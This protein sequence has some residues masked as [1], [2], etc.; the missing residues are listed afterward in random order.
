MNK[1][2]IHTL[3][4]PEFSKTMAR[5]KE[6]RENDPTLQVVGLIDKADL[7]NE[8]FMRNI[9]EATQRFANF[10]LEP[11]DIIIA[12]NEGETRFS[13]AEWESVKALRDRLMSKGITFGFDDYRQIWSVEEVETANAKIDKSADA[14]RGKSFSPL[15]KLLS[16][17]LDVTR[18]NYK[19]EDQTEHFSQSRSVMGVLNSD[20]IVCVGFSA[21]LKAIIEREGDQNI[22]IFTNHVA[23]SRDNEYVSGYH[24]NLVIYINDPKYGL[25][26][27][28]YVDPTWDCSRGQRQDFNLNHFLVPLKDIEHLNTYILDTS[29]TKPKAPAT[30]I[31]KAPHVTVKTAKAMAKNKH[32][33]YNAYLQR[34]TSFSGE[35]FVMS[36]ELKEHA[37]GN[38]SLAQ[39]L[40]EY[41]ALADEIVNDFE[42]HFAVMGRALNDIREYFVELGMTELPNEVGY[43]FDK[44]IKQGKGV[45]EL[46]AYADK[47]A[48]AYTQGVLNGNKEEMKQAFLSN[49][50]TKLSDF[51]MVDFYAS[52]LASLER[53]KGMLDDAEH[54]SAIEDCKQKLA[55]QTEA[56]EQILMHIGHMF[57]TNPETM[58]DIAGRISIDEMVSSFDSFILDL[59]LLDD[60]SAESIEDCINK[61]TVLIFSTKLDS[62]FSMADRAISSRR[63]EER[64][65]LSTQR[66]GTFNEMVYE[67]FCDE[68]TPLGY[69]SMQRALTEVL[70]KN[71]P[72]ATPQKVKE[73][74]D[75]IMEHN[76][77]RAC[78]CF[79]EGASNAFYVVGSSVLAHE[80]AEREGRN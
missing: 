61:S 65:K 33:S 16:A 58:Y 68:S 2:Y 20:K 19:F 57:D 8:E 21:L 69:E 15:E 74:V 48:N 35:R 42:A 32:K 72:N 38:R 54:L 80:Q 18:H 49:L 71:H 12:L 36:P 34:S 52:S 39:R 41:T 46:I 60:I 23:C 45:D 67:A 28:Y 24:Q 31:G 30:P 51:K 27:Y 1:F 17:Y 3:E 29:T 79:R 40:V 59:G 9:G 26:G 77:E 63:S 66:L 56:I 11:H 76:A 7:M 70:S 50:R 47:V 78:R 75:A 53:Q 6:L 10:G 22:K 14:L 25:N 62:I 64:S 43:E 44:I 55:E 73:V 13:P 37:K 5:F 4:E